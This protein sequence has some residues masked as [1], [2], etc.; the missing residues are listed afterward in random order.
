MKSIEQTDQLAI[1]KAVNA[2]Y[3][4]GLLLLN[5]PHKRNYNIS[6]FQFGPCNVPN[7]LLQPSSRSS[8]TVD[9]LPLAVD[10]PPIIG[11][12]QALYNIDKA[13]T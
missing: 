11:F 3:H 10:H 4:D 2:E 13:T 5:L 1:D 7:P 8:S 9:Y 12:S 6:A